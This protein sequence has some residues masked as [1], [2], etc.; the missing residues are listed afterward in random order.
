LA[1]YLS[2]RMLC[3]SGARRLTADLWFRWASTI[4]IQ[5]SKAYIISPNATWSPWYNWAIAHLA[6][7]NNHS[8]THSLT[9][10][11]IHSRVGIVQRRHYYHLLYA[12]K[13]VLG[14]TLLRN[15]SL[16]LNNNQSLTHSLLV[17]INWTWQIS[18]FATTINIKM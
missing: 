13:L 10:S 14:M 7:N 3:P 4:K 15:V 6:L 11:L 1:W 12:A 16:T 5:L 8:L 17:N 18:V 2:I 9:H